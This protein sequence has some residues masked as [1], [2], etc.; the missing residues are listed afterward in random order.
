MKMVHNFWQVVPSNKK[1]KEKDFQRLTLK[2][3]F[4]ILKKFFTQLSITDKQISGHKA[5]DY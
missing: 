2:S 4:R 1:S 3:H 5:L